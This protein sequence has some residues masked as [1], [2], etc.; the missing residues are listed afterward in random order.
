MS[1][2]PLVNIIVT[3]F[4]SPKIRELFLVGWP[5]DFSSFKSNYFLFFFAIQKKIIKQY[6]FSVLFSC[7][8]AVCEVMH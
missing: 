7:L 1:Y 6:R 3:S 4:L 2:L 8:F 5:Y